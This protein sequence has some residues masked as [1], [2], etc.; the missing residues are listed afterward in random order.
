MDSRPSLDQ[1]ALQSAL[2]WSTRSTCSWLQVGAVLVR[3]GHEF[4]QGYNGAA[5]GLPH[6]VHVDEVWDRRRTHAPGLVHAEI[7]ALLSAGRFGHPTL[8]ATLYTTHSPCCGCAGA[9]INAG[10]VE[11]AY[12]RT[13]RDE[14]GIDLLRSADVTVRR[15]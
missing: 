1:V 12:G 3:D 4:A 2:A 13:F 8:G 10:I 6:C 11:V 14:S 9:I 15:I 5:R 7:N